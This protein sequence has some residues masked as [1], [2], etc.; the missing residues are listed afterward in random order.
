MTAPGAGCRANLHGTKTRRLTERRRGSK[1]SRMDLSTIKGNFMNVRDRQS[2]ERGITRP[3][4][5]ANA[6][7]A[8]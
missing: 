1:G 2:G 6:V 5:C 7:Q 3:T 8:R 4:V